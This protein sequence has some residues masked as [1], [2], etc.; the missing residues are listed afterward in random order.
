V[1][2]PK[3]KVGRETFGTKR[4]YGEGLWMP[5]SGELVYEMRPNGTGEWQPLIA[6]NAGVLAVAPLA[7]F[8]A[9]F[10]GTSD[11]TSILLLTGSRMK[12]YRPRLAWKHITLGEG[13]ATRMKSCLH[14][15][16]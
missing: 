5:I 3:S 11:M 16:W 14:D 12:V 15:R 7:Q 13:P 2:V 1:F 8:R 6:D 4:I 9:R 10:V